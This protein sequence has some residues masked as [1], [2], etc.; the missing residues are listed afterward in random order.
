MMALSADQP[1]RDVVLWPGVGGRQPPFDLHLLYQN[2][3]YLVAELTNLGH[4]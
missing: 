2:V 3:L 4:G 1:V